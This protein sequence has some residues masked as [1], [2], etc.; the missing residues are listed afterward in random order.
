MESLSPQSV[1]S[2]KERS[3]ISMT[4]FKPKPRPVIDHEFACV[5][6]LYEPSRDLGKYTPLFK[7]DR[8]RV[9]LEAVTETMFVCPKCKTMHLTKDFKVEDKIRRKQIRQ[10]HLRRIEKLKKAYKP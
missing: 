5:N 7:R 9:K 6:C 4:L 8:I 2:K 3:E 1:T 10:K